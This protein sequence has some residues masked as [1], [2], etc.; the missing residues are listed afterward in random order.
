MDVATSPTMFII[1]QDVDG[2]LYLKMGQAILFSGVTGC[3]VKWG[4]LGQF[5]SRQRYLTQLWKQSQ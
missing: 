3:I 1:D 2:H 4:P 5:K